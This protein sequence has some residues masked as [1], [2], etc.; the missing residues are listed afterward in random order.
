[1]CQ[2]GIFEIIMLLCF[3]AAW[4]FSIARSFR[5]RST[6]GKSFIFTAVIFAGYLAGIIHKTNCNPDSVVSLY[7]FNATLVLVDMALYLRNYVVERK[8][9][10]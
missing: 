1:M 8:M 10:A 9:N 5:S 2:T 3:S 6:K 4:P 7:I